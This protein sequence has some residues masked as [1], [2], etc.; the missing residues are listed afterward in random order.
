MR[1][2]SLCEPQRMTSWLNNSLLS[3]TE[4]RQQTIRS[5]LALLGRTA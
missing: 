5:S 1:R 4:A 3:A 2:G